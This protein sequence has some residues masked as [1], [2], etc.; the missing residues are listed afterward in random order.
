MFSGLQEHWHVYS[1]HASVNLMDASDNLTPL[2]HCVEY[3]MGLQALAIVKTYIEH[4]AN[5]NMRMEGSD[6]MTA[7]R[8]AVG[9]KQSSAVVK[10]LVG[11][12][13]ADEEL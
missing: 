2:H 11:S 1:W 13:E 10:L 6:K 12:Q 8:I 9:N 3:T 4:K 5:V 7:L